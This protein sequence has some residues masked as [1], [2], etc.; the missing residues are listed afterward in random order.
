MDGALPGDRPQALRQPGAR[1]AGSRA[2]PA[3]RGARRG[4]AARRGLPQDAGRRGLRLLR[5]RPLRSGDPGRGRGDRRPQG[6]HRPARPLLRRPS[7]PSAPT[8]P[9]PRS[10]SGISTWIST[11][12]EFV[13]GRCSL[14]AATGALRV[15][16]ENQ[17]GA[18]SMKRMFSAR[19]QRVPC[20]RP[21]RR[22]RSTYCVEGAYPPFSGDRAGRL[23]RRLRHRHRHG[24]LQ[25]DRRDL[26]AGEG[27][28][29]RHH[30][31]AAREEVRRHHRLDVGDR[32]AQAGH[33][34]HRQVLPGPEPFRRQGRCR[35]GRHA[36]G[37]G[38]QGG[39]RPARH[40]PPGLHGGALSR[41]R[42][43]ALRHPGRDDAR[44]HGRPDRR[45]DGGRASRSTRASWRRRPARASPFSAENHFDPAIH[46]TGALDRRAQ[47]GHRA[48]RPAHARRSPAIRADGT[49]DT[50]VAKYFDFDIYGD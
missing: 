27:R 19:S 44:P 32:G 21:R 17:Q 20:R 34:L 48:A 7:P 35:P 1:A 33:R 23:D 18:F 26:R 4:G 45:G 25:A 28:L 24:A 47:G 22:S 43:P 8:A 36:R 40:H 46:G 41:H 37:P 11:A 31:G 49:Y 38:R 9:T 5:R 50:I 2:R 15:L 29:G 13:A 42:A 12:I 3:R 6:G 39:R 10:R 16:G 14:D 30:S